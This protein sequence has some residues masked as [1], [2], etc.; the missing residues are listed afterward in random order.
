MF[1]S[2]FCVFKG[3]FSQ[4]FDGQL[5][6]FMFLD[7]ILHVARPNLTVFQVYCYY[8]VIKIRI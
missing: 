2:Q 5:E 8:F 7:V 3:Y 6:N 1:L 4:I